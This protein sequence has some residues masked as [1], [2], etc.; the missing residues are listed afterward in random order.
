MINMI[1]DPSERARLTEEYRRVIDRA[2]A[3]LM[4]VIVSVSDVVKQASQKQFNDAIAEIWNDQHQLPEHER[5]SP[6]MLR[7][8]DHRQTNITDCLQYIFQFKSQF[9]LNVLSTLTSYT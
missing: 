3:D 4:N 5:L 7:L 8:I 6:E 1:S 9:N 2:K